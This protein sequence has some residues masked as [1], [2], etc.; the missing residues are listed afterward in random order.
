MITISLCM[1]I[2]DEEDVLN[3]CLRSIEG[4]PD[5]IIIVDTGSKDRSKEFAE[6]WTDKVFDY[7]WNHHF[8]E[9]RN[10]S[11]KKASKDYILWLDADDTIEKEDALKLKKLK[12]TLSSDID[13]VSMVYHTLAD[14][15]GNVQSATRRLRLT[16]RA[17]PFT[18][19]GAVHEDL[20]LN[21]SFSQLDSD[22]TIKHKKDPSKIASDRNLQI[23]EALLA[24]GR[25][26]TAHDEFH[27]ARE[28]HKHKKYPKAIEAYYRFLRNKETAPELQLYVFDKLA[29]C[30]YHLGNKE[31]EREISL[32]TFEI[33]IP[34]PEFSCRM[35]EYFLEKNMYA[36]S[37][38]W[39]LQ[40]IDAPVPSSYI[41]DESQPYRTWLPH[42]QLGYCYFQ[43]GKYQL[44][45][46]HTEKILEF[47]PED[48]EAKQNLVMLKD[49]V[50]EERIE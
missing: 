6:K 37:A 24:S 2:K 3:R 10:F 33:D 49:L 15:Y 11:F 41:I 14:D 8:S 44:S 45:L 20:H 22:I 13:A 25:G 42:K 38:Y 7:K 4:I 32:K 46:Y 23:Y 1:I 47:L 16:K 28:L 30:Y 43:L 5:E 35:A 27:Y 40:A 12:E 21:E 26:L 39:Y 29:S 50:R 31:K 19:Y 18:W 17:K 36:Q 34:R 9:A 48:K